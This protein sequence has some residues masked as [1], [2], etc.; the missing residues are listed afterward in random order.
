[1][2]FKKS[3]KIDA[4]LAF[5]LIIKYSQPIYKENLNKIITICV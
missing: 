1:M 5:C 3:L 2:L 4:Y